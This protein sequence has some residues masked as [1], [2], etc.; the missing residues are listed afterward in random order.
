MRA[1]ALRPTLLLTAA[2]FSAAL[3]AQSL[4]APPV[5]PA[6]VTNYEY[7][8]QGNPTKTIQAPGVA[9]FNFATSASYDRL[10]RAK[11]TTDAKAGV[12]RFEY[13]GRAELTQVTDPR[14][15]VTQ[16]PRNGLGDVTGLDSP[17]TGVATN[18]L[19]DAA[20][21]LKT[22]TDSRGVQATYTYDALNRATSVVYS[23][24]GQ[25][26][27]TYSYSYDQTGAGF[28]NGVGRL[29]STAAPTGSSKYAYDAQGRLT[30][31]TQV[32]NAQ[33]G[34]NTGA[35]T[36]VTGYA[37]DSAGNP[38]SITYPSGRVLTLSYVGGQLDAMALKASATASAVN[39]VTS[40]QWEPFGAPKSWLWQQGAATRLH[41][42][43]YDAYGRLVRYRLGSVIR[44]LSYDAADRIT[45]YTHYDA[46]T[47]TANP[48]LN[49]GF[50]YDELGR[51]TTITT[52]A[53]S[54]T[55]GYDANG[56][57]T[58]VTQGATT[59]AY[60]TPT[61]SNRL[62]S[63]TNPANTFTH[64]NAG[65]TL[66]GPS[67]GNSYTA[68]YNLEGRLATMK[69][70]STTTTYAHDAMGQRSRKY[71]S[72]NANT[73]LIFVYDQQGHLLGEYSNS[74]AA[75]RE[76]VWLGDEPVAMF[77][78]ASGNQPPTVFHI[79]NDHLGTPRAVLN[80]S[81]GLRWRWLAEPFGTTAPETNPAALGAFTFNLRHPGQY[82]DSETGLFYNYF[83]DYDAGTGRYVQSDPIGLQG[84]INTY[85]YVEGNPLSYVDPMGLRGGDR[86]AD[87]ETLC[88]LRGNNPTICSLLRPSQPP[89]CICSDVVLYQQNISYSSGG[90]TD[91]GHHW[92]EIGDS[93]SYGYWP[94]GPVGLVGTFRGVPGSVNRG[95]SV[96]PHHGDRQN[97]DLSRLARSPANNQRSCR[98]TCD[99][100][101]QCIRD[102]ARTYTNNHGATWSWRAEILDNNCHTFQRRMRSQ[103]SID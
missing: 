51:L 24:T 12:T 98:E 26:S 101:R 72:S 68:T 37:Y 76:Y 83:R 63:L 23:Q 9:G 87:P 45:A 18:T 25:T 42:R 13:N 15:L 2:L 44:D 102:F 62:T 38:T 80:T 97:L 28:A 60:T 41:E 19:L 43:L 11:D 78:P 39:L 70:G 48:S 1:H 66:T 77:T 14:N 17:D 47:A 46:T 55:I 67:A 56:N 5:S 84:G 40:V 96:D 31:A 58:S 90:G 6:P 50:G 79:H 33:S 92:T 73:T 49:Q 27:R 52:S 21:N 74:G 7:D 20:G 61:T 75:L 10:E 16:Y 64:D 4:P 94:D 99:Q 36:R 22:R 88:L 89:P 95:L 32:V 57:R 30:S 93:E 86:A 53:T 35:I 71:A 85:T 81:N 3:Q 100:M 82:A 69:V 59:R 91:Y 65:N 34:A 54:W 29:T 8:A 103:C